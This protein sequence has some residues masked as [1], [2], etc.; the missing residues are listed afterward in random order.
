[1]SVLK[2][3]RVE[4]GIRRLRA[5]GLKVHLHLKNENEGYI[6][7]DVDSVIQYIIRQ[8][9]KSLKYPKRRIYYDKD[10]NVVAIHVWKGKGDMLWLGKKK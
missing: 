2:D 8:I 5:M 1:M 6:F 9:D 3:V 10:L 4:K 7:I